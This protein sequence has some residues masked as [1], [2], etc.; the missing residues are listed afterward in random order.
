MS[1]GVNAS[2]A[3]LPRKRKGGV[4]DAFKALWS[5]PS[6][7]NVRMEPSGLPEDLRQ[8]IDTYRDVQTR[9]QNANSHS[10]GQN[11]QLAAGSALSVPNEQLA[12]SLQY[13]NVRPEEYAMYRQWVGLLQPELAN[14]SRGEDTASPWLPPVVQASGGYASSPPAGAIMEMA[15][16]HP[17]RAELPG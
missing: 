4:R 6:R 7:E 15:A 9:I 5:S 16:D 2:S 14:T 3:S 13:Y 11:Q 10:F 12:Y 1:D 17:F 8:W